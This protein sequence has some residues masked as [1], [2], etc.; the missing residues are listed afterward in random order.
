MGAPSAR[1]FAE[2][3][4][5]ELHRINNFLAAAKART[6]R[7]ILSPHNFGRDRVGGQSIPIGAAGVPI[8][9]F[10]DFSNKVAAAFAGN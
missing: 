6:V 3:D 10:A 4:A 2:L 1:F 8:E 9:A 7:V 5:G